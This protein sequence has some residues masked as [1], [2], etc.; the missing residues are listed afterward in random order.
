[1]DKNWQEADNLYLEAK[2]LRSQEKFL[3]A[4]DLFRKSSEKEKSS[5]NPRMEDL[6]SELNAAGHCY[7]VSGENDKAIQFFTEAMQI[8]ED[9]DQPS[10]VAKFMNNIGMIH[11]AQ[12]NMERAIELYERAAEIFESLQMITEAETCR[13]NIRT[14]SDSSST[15]RIAQDNKKDQ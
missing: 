8:A 11:N 9:T 1:M 10:N 4:A 14:S 6:C 3:E 5:E 7:Y 12:G 13:E 2:K 15:R